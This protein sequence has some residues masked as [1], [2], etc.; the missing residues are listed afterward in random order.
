MGGLQMWLKGLLLFD[1]RNSSSTFLDLF[2]P[3][4]SRKQRG[5][6]ECSPGNKT[7]TESR[8][9]QIFTKQKFH[10]MVCLVFDAEIMQ[11]PIFIFLMR[12]KL[13]FKKLI[14]NC[15]VYSNCITNFTNFTN[16]TYLKLNC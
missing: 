4:M 2:H 13:Q 16:S 5:K 3:R 12:I 14:D 10:F 6:L 8:E 1:L 7:Q 9:M 11:F 15:F